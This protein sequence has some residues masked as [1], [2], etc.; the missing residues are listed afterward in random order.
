MA[1]P[2]LLQE[3]IRSVLARS[4]DALRALV[5]SRGLPEDAA[6]HVRQTLEALPGLL[7]A[8][9]RA[10]RRAPDHPE[11]R[12]L[13]LL[14]LSYLLQDDDLL[15]SRAGRPVLGLLDDVYLVH[16]A[17]QELEPHL[18]RVDMRSIAGGAELL[19]GLLPEHVVWALDAAVE[20]AGT[21]AAT[22]I[23]KG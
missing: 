18:G 16:R 1:I 13:F 3:G 4:D 14:V 15:P 5:T 9:D 21:E 20:Q 19:R 12:A 2:G 6:E 7:E 23:G 10:L 8:M 17:A 11:A 22:L